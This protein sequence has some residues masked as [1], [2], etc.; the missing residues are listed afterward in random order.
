[1]SLDESQRRRTAEE[2]RANLE[3]AE[4]QEHHFREDLGMEP[5][6]LAA[7]V[8]MDPGVRSD[9]VWLLRDYLDAAVRLRG[10]T[11][12]PWATMTEPARAAADAWFGLAQAPTPRL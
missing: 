9:R 4:L 12:R 5:D 6:E 11:P 8:A 2:F 10:R 1:M 7:I 3:L